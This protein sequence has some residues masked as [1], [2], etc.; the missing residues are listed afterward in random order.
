MSSFLILSLEKEE[1]R[2]INVIKTVNKLIIIILTSSIIILI[3]FKYIE[4]SYLAQL[5]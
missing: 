1:L 3:T 4:L 2:V 5:S